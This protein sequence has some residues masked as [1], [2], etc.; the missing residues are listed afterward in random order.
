MLT[1]A[2]QISHITKG[3][4]FQIS[5]PQSDE[6]IWQKGFRAVFTS[7]WDPWTCRLSN[8]VL[9]PF[10]LEICLSTFLTVFNFG[11]T[12]ALTIMF[13]F[14]IV[15]NLMEIREM[16]QEIGRKCFIFQIIA[17]ELRAANSHN[18]EVD[19]CH[20]EWKCWP[21][22]PRFCISLRETFS[23]SV[24]FRVVKQHDK[25]ALMQISHTFG[26]L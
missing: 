8:G 21:I 25:I 5:F 7:V 19:T 9:K 20:W 26:T 12:L 2:P 13:F 3:D 23:K 6:K 18:S 4:I 10:C 14:Q 1:N 16:K 24:S 15:Q 11:N 17:S 22:S